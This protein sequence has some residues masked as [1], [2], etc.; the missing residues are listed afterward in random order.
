MEA[1]EDLH[2]G[3]NAINEEERNVGK[4]G[5]KEQSSTQKCKVGDRNPEDESTSNDMSIL[6]N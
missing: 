4:T 6:P 2:H 5:Y 1:D 3:V